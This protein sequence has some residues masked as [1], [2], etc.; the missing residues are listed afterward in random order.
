MFKFFSR[1]LFVKN[2]ALVIIGLGFVFAFAYFFYSNSSK[3][4]ASYPTCVPGKI[5]GSNEQCGL[6]GRCILKSGIGRCTCLSITP[7]N[8][9]TPTKSLTPTNNPAPTM[10]TPTPTSAPSPTL[11]PTPTLPEYYLKT[12]EW[13]NASPNIASTIIFGCNPGDIAVG[14]GMDGYSGPINIWRTVRSGPTSSTDLN[15][16]QT[17]VINESSSTYQYTVTAKC[18]KLVK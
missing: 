4:R 16:W 15:G 3:S 7:T 8:N 10:P 6:Y 12:S 2:V 5:C 18:L 14:G 17:T 1:Q 13:I 11:T 9:P